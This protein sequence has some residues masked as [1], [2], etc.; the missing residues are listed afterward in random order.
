MSTTPP[1]PEPGTPGAA[2]TA[3]KLAN[4]TIDVA[5]D[6]GKLAVDI[7]VDTAKV[8]LSKLKALVSKVE[9]VVK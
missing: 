9:D 3:K 6:L 4:Q 1:T 7:P 5:E 2:D 8:L